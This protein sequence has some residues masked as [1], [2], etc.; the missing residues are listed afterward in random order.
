MT[1]HSRCNS[2]AYAYAG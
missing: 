1:N 2:W